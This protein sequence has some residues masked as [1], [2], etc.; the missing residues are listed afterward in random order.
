MNSHLERRININLNSNTKLN[1]NLNMHVNMHLNLN[2]I[3]NMIVN[4]NIDLKH[5]SN[6]NLFSMPMMPGTAANSDPL[7]NC[8]Q[9]STG[10]ESLSH[11]ATGCGR[12]QPVRRRFFKQTF[13]KH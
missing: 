9:V 2:G 12:V 11:A 1:T 10:L 6:L 4:L 3:S 7:K 13:K 5:Q 8:P